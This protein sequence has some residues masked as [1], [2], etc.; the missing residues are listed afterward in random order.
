M[1]EVVHCFSRRKYVLVYLV[2]IRRMWFLRLRRFTWVSCFKLI[3][4]VRTPS[5]KPVVLPHKPSHRYTSLG[6]YSCNH[7][8]NFVCSIS[9]FS[10]SWHWSCGNFHLTFLVN[11]YRLVTLPV[12]NWSPIHTFSIFTTHTH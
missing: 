12:G 3:T 9:G 1:F 11:G 5:C 6:A 10:Y 4:D 7:I 2:I 8:F